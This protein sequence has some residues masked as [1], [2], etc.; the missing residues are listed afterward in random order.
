[1]G[2][3]NDPFLQVFIL[4][5]LR[6][7]GRGNAEASDA[8]SDVLAQ[9]ATN[10]D[11][12][13][14]AGNAILY[15]CVQVRWRVVQWGAPSFLCW[16]MLCC[17]LWVLSQRVGMWLAGRPNPALVHSRATIWFTSM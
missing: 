6:V 14:N 16:C 3:I 8:M 4:R 10:T 17:A 1:V 15:E 11:S 13:R 7:L 9:V 2:G 5:L 12:A